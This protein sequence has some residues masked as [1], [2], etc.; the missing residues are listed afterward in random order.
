MN[1]VSFYFL[2]FWVCFVY[3]SLT[4]HYI[5][6]DAALCDSWIS[7]S[8]WQKCSK[9]WHFLCAHHFFDPFFSHFFKNSCFI[10]RCG[11]GW[12]GNR[13]HISATPFQPPTSSLLQNG[14][15]VKRSIFQFILRVFHF[16]YFCLW[17][18]W[19]CRYL[20]WIGYRFLTD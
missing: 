9:H 8:L 10:H 17:L 18:L 7:F 3:F 16:T 12:K 20:D 2:L 13:C 6:F 15:S 1:L 4:F 5:N 11:K 19:F 14:R